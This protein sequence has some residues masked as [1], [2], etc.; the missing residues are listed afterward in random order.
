MVHTVFIWTVGG[1]DNCGVLDDKIYKKKKIS[2][3]SS[4]HLGK[5]D[6]NICRVVMPS[7]AESG[8]YV[9]AGIQ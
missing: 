4:E 5:K 8:F 7:F 2:S 9:Y 6:I 3:S 1:V